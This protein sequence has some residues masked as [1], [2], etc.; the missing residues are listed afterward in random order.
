M[1]RHLQNQYNLISSEMMKLSTSEYVAKALDY[2]ESKNKN[3]LEEEK[4]AEYFYPNGTVRRLIISSIEEILIASKCEQ[5][6]TNEKTGLAKMIEAE[7]IDS[8]KNLY[9][10]LKR[11]SQHKMYAKYYQ[12]FI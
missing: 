11:T 4:A 2:L 7:D 1:I 9:K 3:I 10:L 12:S 6:I 5:L 8:L